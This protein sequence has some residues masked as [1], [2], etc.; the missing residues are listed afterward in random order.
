[1]NNDAGIRSTILLIDDEEPLLEVLST[2]LYNAGYDFLRASNAHGALKLLER[3]PEIDVVVSD[4]RM[5]G[6]DGIELI[7]TVRERYSDRTWLQIIFITGH[8]TL[9]NSIGA[10]R[11]SAADFLHKPVQGREFITSINTAA[12]KAQDLRTEMNWRQ[13]GN[14][15]LSRLIEEVQKLGAVLN[16]SSPD[17]N[18][19]TLSASAA[20]GRASSDASELPNNERLS[21][22]LRIR[23]VRAQFFPGKLFID[24]AWHI[25]LELME[26]YLAGTTI[27]AFSLFVVSGVPTATASRRLEEMESTGLVR[28]WV[29]PSD[30]RRQLVALTDAAVEL[31]YS[32]LT[33]LDQQLRDA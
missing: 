30:G 29:D 17:L 4:I 22:L 33:A 31:M 11:L 1:V 24:P 19:A 8:A 16:Q 9:D 15:R 25:M 23:D 26:N 27:T 20:D 28:R 2:A 21:E 10:L 13:V 7:R 3:T 32:Y 12:K 5:P 14:D 18:A 6:M